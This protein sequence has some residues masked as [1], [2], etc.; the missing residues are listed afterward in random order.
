MG[1]AKKRSFNNGINDKFPYMTRE[2]ALNSVSKEA[3]VNKEIVEQAK[4]LVEDLQGESL[5]DRIFSWKQITSPLKEL[6]EKRNG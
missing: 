3:A 4:A 1:K 5:I 2:S 6:F